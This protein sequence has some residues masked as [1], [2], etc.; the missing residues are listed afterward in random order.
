M[1]KK[2]NVSVEETGKQ[3]VVQTTGVEKQ[4]EKAED[5]QEKTTDNSGC[6]LPEKFHDV[7]ALA[8]AYNALQA[9]FTRRSQRLK[10]LE[11]QAENFAKEKEQAEFRAEKQEDGASD[12]LPVAEPANPFSPSGETG[13][14][15]VESPKD[16]NEVLFRQVQS[17][18]AVRLKIIGDYLSSLSKPTAPLTVLGTGTPTAPVQKAK[19]LEDANKMALRYFQKEN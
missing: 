10:E 1:K 7:N 6:G 8:N 3:E 16:E 9:E 12:S 19:T 11:A 5:K 17:N 15:P 14:K 13:L 2:E 18:E 4:T